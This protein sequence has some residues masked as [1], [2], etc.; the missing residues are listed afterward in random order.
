M[1][2]DDNFDPFAECKCKHKYTIIDD[3]LYFGRCIHFHGYNLGQLTDRSYNCL[4]ILN[5]NLKNDTN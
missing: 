4:E 3:T 2:E 1:N 5:G